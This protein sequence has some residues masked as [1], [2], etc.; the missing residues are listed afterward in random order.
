MSET[1][2]CPACAEE[3][4]MAAVVCKHCG[5][6]LRPPPPQARTKGDAYVRIIAGMVFIGV[7]LI[8]FINIVGRA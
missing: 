4:Q 5:L 2:R 8:V 3:I 6:D 1:K 7:I